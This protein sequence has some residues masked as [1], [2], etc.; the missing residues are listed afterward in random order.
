MPNKI[1]INLCDTFIVA[2]SGRKENVDEQKENRD[3]HLPRLL[4]RL[5]KDIADLVCD[6]SSKNVKRDPVLNE[7]HD[8]AGVA[9]QTRVKLVGDWRKYAIDECHMDDTK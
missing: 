3:R 1:E 4:R 6:T 9:G 5:F 2:V 7:C 8:K